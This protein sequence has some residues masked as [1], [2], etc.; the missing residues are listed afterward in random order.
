[1]SRIWYLLKEGFRNLWSNRMMSLASIGVLISCL[2]LT[3]SAFLFTV[4]LSNA[5]DT[6]QSSSETTVYLNDEVTTLDAV[7]IG[8]KIGSVANVQNYEFVSKEQALQNYM[9][10]LGDDGTLL[11]DL[12]GEENPFP[13]AY[14]VTMEDISKY[15]QTVKQIGKIEGVQKVGSRSDSAEKL[16]NISRMISSVGFWVVLILSIVSLFIISN[17]IRIT[18]FS[19]RL[20]ISIMKSVGA[21][22]W[23]IRIPFV[24]EGII[25]GVIS[26][27]GATL[28]LK[29]LYETAVNAIKQLIPFTKIPFNS[30][31]SQILFGFLLAGILFGA[32]GGVISISR[33]LKEEGG[34]I[35]GW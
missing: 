12:Q 14:R 2:L 32:V 3:G 28:F 31:F 11:E 16:T 33:Y 5:M 10:A 22:D 24:V 25:I 9:E 15:D 23:F 20:E 34:D 19:R 29:L 30:M 21:T 7:Q 17:T 4:N 26:A 35:I 1:M 18:M 13:H 6:I 27:L 8:Q